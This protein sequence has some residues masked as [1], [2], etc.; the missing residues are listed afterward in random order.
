MRE[1]VVLLDTAGEI[2]AEY[3]RHLNW[4]G[5]PGVGDR[6]FLEVT[7]SMAGRVERIDLPKR[8][9]DTYLHFPEDPAL[10]EFDPSD[11]KFAALA[12]HAKAP[13]ANATGTDW[14]HHRAVLVA[15][16]IA[17]DFICGP[18]PARWFE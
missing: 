10:A 16:G 4:R 7:R 13:V 11:R 2:Q 9:D 15:H 6:F 1:G 3:H 5:Q 8:D 18:D 17:L 14:L 12:R